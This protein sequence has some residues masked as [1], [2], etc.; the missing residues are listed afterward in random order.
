M[1]IKG[2]NRKKK[3]TPKI[4]AEEKDEESDN[5]CVND[6]S[7]DDDNDEGEDNGEG[8]EMT[9]GDNDA[10]PIEDEALWNNKEMQRSVTNYLSS[11]FGKYLESGMHISLWNS[12]HMQGED[13][14]KE[15]IFRASP[16]KATQRGCKDGWNDWAI[17]GDGPNND[18]SVLGDE[19]EETNDEQEDFKRYYPMHLVCFLKINP[20][21]SSENADDMPKDSNGNRIQA[22]GGEYALCHCSKLE[23]KNLPLRVSVCLL[24]QEVTKEYKETAHVSA[25]EKNLI[26]YLYPITNIRSSCVCVPDIMP[27]ETTGKNVAFQRSKQNYKMGKNLQTNRVDFLFLV[28]RSEWKETYVNKMEEDLSQHYGGRTKDEVVKERIKRR[29]E[30]KLVLRAQRKADDDRKREREDGKDIVDAPVIPPL[31]SATQRPKASGKGL[32]RKKTTTKTYSTNKNK[33]PPPQARTASQKKKEKTKKQP[34]TRPKR[35]K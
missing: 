18:Q 29:K 5:D 11:K 15:A 33:H 13:G 16:G 26:L 22:K 28:D 17:V 12:F 6:E 2:Q 9:I 24:I 1:Q 10:L 4:I 23:Q 31:D 7:D 3:L 34:T 19:D 27:E 25:A 14:E 21:R 35:N 20:G 32:G 8:D 30:L